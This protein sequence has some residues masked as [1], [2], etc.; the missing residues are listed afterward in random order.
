MN[1]RPV[2]RRCISC[3][4]LLDRQQFWRVIRDN[5]D[6]VVLDKGMGR[7]AYLCPRKDCLEDA[8][9]RKRFQKALR[10][11]VPPNIVEVL[12]ERLNH[13]TDSDSEAI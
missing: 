4:K 3:R 2:L 10:C 9:R 8:C 1:F 6:G 5:Q 7:S 12:Q 13:C 11:Q